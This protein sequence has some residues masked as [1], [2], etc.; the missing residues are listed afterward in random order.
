MVNH[1]LP[2]PTAR[3]R[4]QPPR[5]PPGHCQRST[6]FPLARIRGQTPPPPPPSSSQNIRA[7][8]TGERYASYWNA[9][10]LIS[11]FLASRTQY[12]GTRENW[13]IRWIQGGTK[14]AP[15]SVHFFSFFTQLLVK[16][17]PTNKFSPQIQCLPHSPLLTNP[18]ST[19]ACFLVDLVEADPRDGVW[20][21]VMG[22]ASKPVIN[23]WPLPRVSLISF[24]LPRARSWSASS[25]VLI[26]AIGC[27]KCSMST[28]QLCGYDNCWLL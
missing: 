20:K 5:P 8:C 21:L 11:C 18:G 7:L 9:F 3:V 13:W 25:Q 26:H 16:I 19:T 17:L 27:L 14:D 2:P 12:L 23:K 10:L 4:G 28:L 24:P 22:Q 15:V 1:F 6:T